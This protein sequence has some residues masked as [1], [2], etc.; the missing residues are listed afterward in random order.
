MSIAGVNLLAVLGAAIGGFVFGSV[1]YGALAKPWTKAAGLT[2]PFKAR[3][4]TFI[5]TFLCQLVMAMALTGV[6]FHMGEFSIRRAV[7]SAVLL[8]AGFIVTTMIVNHRFQLA[9]WSLTF[10]DA[11]HWLGVLLVMGLILGSFGG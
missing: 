7:I 3:P 10:I 4:L 9:P 6:I 8:W 2:E 5:I 1:W 11:G